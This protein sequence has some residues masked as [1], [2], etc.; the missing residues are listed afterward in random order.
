VDWIA[1]CLEHLRA[2]GRATIE[3]R[4]EAQ[5]A[6]V[7]HVNAVADRTLYPR[8]NSW[9]VGANIPGKKRVFMPLLGFPAYVEKCNEVAAKDYEGFECR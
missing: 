5:E 8:C 2:A 9:Y 1:R 4:P 7:E 6:W 3:A